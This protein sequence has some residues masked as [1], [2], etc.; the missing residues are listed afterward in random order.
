MIIKALN[1]AAI[2]ALVLA[3]VFLV[4]TAVFGFRSDPQVEAFLAAE[5]VVEQ[6]GKAQGDRITDESGLTSP[7]VKQAQAFGL[8]LNP[9]VRAVNNTQGPPSLPRPTIDSRPATV[10]AKF[11]LVGT[12]FYAVHPDL[13]LALID[14]P[15]K[16]LHWVRRSSQV[17]HLL[18]DQ[19]KDGLVVVKDGERTF[20]L[21]A[22]RLP[23]ISLIK[24]K[25]DTKAG[26]V[27]ASSS[28]SYLQLPAGRKQA[29][30][31]LVNKIMNMQAESAGGQAGSEG[32]DKITAASEMLSRF[33]DMSLSAEEAKGLDNLGRQLQE[34]SRGALPPVPDE[35]TKIES[36][37][38]MKE[39]TAADP[40]QAGQRQPVRRRIPRAPIRRPVRQPVE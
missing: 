5:G 1:T 8:Y 29:F 3:V 10:S 26:E 9:P 21:V 19:I 34:R 7:L 28:S 14:E 39:K 6:S 24:G 18:I 27:S 35:T 32:R 20:E 2:L 37:N 11:K 17:G 4:V 38:I 13:S 31:D 12:S 36:A 23:T 40:N 16:G 15:G 30:D 25:T 33:R 22:E